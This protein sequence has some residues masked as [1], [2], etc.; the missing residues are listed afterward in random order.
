MRR[1]GLPILTAVLLAG[2]A[3]AEVTDSSP[4]GFEIHHSVEIAAPAAKVWD[5]LVAPGRWWSSQHSWSGKAQNHTLDPRP[6]GCWCEALPNGGGALHMTVIYVAPGR[7]LRL[8]GQTGPFQFTGAVNTMDWKLSE[9]DGHTTLSLTFDA[10][11]YVKGGIGDLT[12]P[13]D[14]VMGEQ[15]DRLKRYVETGAAE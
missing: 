12:A 15:I 9:K 3:R 6:G 2:A 13:V 10:G 11:G 14:R 4:S 8:F 1:S 7:E 5:A